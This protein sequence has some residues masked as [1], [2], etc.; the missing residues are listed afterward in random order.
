MAMPS[1]SVV[2]PSYNQ[3]RFIG[4]TIQS[5]LSQG[6][7]DLEYVVMDGGSTDETVA[8]LE[9]YG[10]R[11]RFRSER[12]KGQPDAVNK[13]IAATSGEV[14]AWINSDD[15]YY[16]GAFQ[17][18]LEVFANRPEVDVVYGAADHIDVDDAVI[19]PYPAE[20]FSLSRLKDQCIICQPA[21]FFRRRVVERLGAL[22]LR[23][24]YTLDY[25]FWL[26]LAKGGAV[27]ACLPQKL[28][29]SR[30]YPETKTSGAKVTVHAEIND[31][32]VATFGR[33]PDRWLCNYAH[34]LVR[35]RWKLGEA[36]PFFTPAVALAALRASWRW[37][38]D[39][40]PVLW[41]TTASWLT[42][43]LIRPGGAA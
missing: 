43:G 6:I 7:A 23:W 17:A 37:N 36:S 8:V 2:T 25:E 11:L 34:V 19:E 32:M 42:R 21:A 1:V 18:V 26:R 14:I 24:Q 41:R 10:N 40:S 4:R 27:F 39:V 15:V 33:A 5:V 9:G 16:P 13:G 35:E 31:M 30:F 20:P 22:D 38:R 12:D 29:G 28:A 3:G